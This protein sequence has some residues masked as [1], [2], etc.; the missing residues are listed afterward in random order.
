MNVPFTISRPARRGARLVTWLWGAYHAGLSVEL[1]GR[2][3]E[4]DAVRAAAERAPEP[5]EVMAARHLVQ[6][7]PLVRRGPDGKR[8]GSR[9][10][11]G[12]NAASAIT[13]STTRGRLRGSARAGRSRSTMTPAPSPAAQT[14][15]CTTPSR[16]R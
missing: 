8:G 12:Q 13:S 11:V 14:E 16:R 4:E 5:V 9:P 1:E 2:G 15:A 6:R 10:A 3:E 7:G